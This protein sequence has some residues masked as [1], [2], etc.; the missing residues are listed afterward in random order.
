M[1][2]YSKASEEIKN[3]FDRAMIV[4]EKKWEER[5]EKIEEDNETILKMLGRVQIIEDNYKKN[6]NALWYRLTLIE[7]RLTKIEEKLGITQ[8]EEEKD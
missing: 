5:I 1:Y 8:E 7:N 2:E 3:G 4:Y 6:V